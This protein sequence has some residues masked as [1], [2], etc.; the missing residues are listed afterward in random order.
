VLEITRHTPVAELPALL[1]PEEAAA[2]LNTGL[3][4]VYE[5]ARRNPDFAVRLGR[6]L[7]VRRDALAKLAGLNGTGEP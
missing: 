3:T 2:W 1:R 7:R 5:L 4:T 6:L